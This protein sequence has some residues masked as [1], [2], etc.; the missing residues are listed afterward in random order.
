VTF[1]WTRSINSFGITDADEAAFEDLP[2]G[3]S[4]ETGWFKKDGH[5]TAYEEI[6]RD[7]TEDGDFGDSN[8]SASSCAWILQS[9]DGRA[10]LGKIGH[11]FMGM[12]QG[13]DGSF[14]VR[15]EVYKPSRATWETAFESG[16]VQETPRAV[17]ALRI[18][19]RLE[20]ESLMAKGEKIQVS[21]REY[22]IQGLYIPE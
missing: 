1:Q 8:T 17:E 18:E 21:S 22:V 4:L 13:E 3:D 9:T 10:F 12:R 2:N 16:Q 7:V 14:A 19:S 20:S 15:S 5:M 6:W 11:T